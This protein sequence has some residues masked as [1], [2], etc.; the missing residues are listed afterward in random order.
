[1][2]DK[3]FIQYHSGLYGFKCPGCGMSHTVNNEI[4]TLSWKNDKPTLSPSVLDQWMSTKTGKKEVCHMFVRDGK[5]QYL[6]DCTHKLKGQTV[7]MELFDN[8]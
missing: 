1:M 8:A 3:Y 7:E 5:I 6:N 2:R 4:W